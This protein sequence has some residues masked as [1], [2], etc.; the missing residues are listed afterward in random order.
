MKDEKKD[1][2]FFCGEGFKQHERPDHHHLKGREN[3]LLTSDK[4]IVLCHRKC[5]DAYHH[6]SVHKVWWYNDFLDRIKEIDD[7]LY[8]REILKLDK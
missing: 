5:H 4:Y 2:C 6:S 8:Y 3:E 7:R 1:F